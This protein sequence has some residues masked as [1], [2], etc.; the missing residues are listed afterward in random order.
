MAKFRPLP[1]SRLTNAQHFAF[2]D[3]FIKYANQTGFSAAKVLAA[4][5][6]LVTV[7]GSENDLYM[8]VKASEI[9][10]QKEAADRRRDSY[11]TRLHR[12]VQAWAGSGMAVLDAA[13][14]ELLKVFKLY[15]INTTAQLDEE[16]GLLLNL[17]TDLS[18]AENLARIEAINGTYLFEQL[19]AAN[20]EVVSLRLEQGVEESDKVKGALAAARKDT[21]ASYDAF[22][23]IIEGA[24]VFADDP[25]QYEQ[26][27]KVW[28]GTLKIYQDMLDRK[29]GS[30]SN[31]TSSETGNS[32]DSGNSGES[33]ETGNSGETG[34]SGD[35]GNSGESGNSGNS[36]ESGDNGGQQGGDNGGDDNGGGGGQ[37]PPVIDQD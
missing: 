15:K 3:A 11:Y 35:S 27:I 13:A 20:N 22:C 34:D 12:L 14:T 2:V 32:G 5:Q 6:T 9:I 19:V 31:G 28:N 30:G 36:G 17:I 7:F 21:D 18:T 25:T 24:S 1:K 33:G 8:V 26:F 10:A 4:L 16:T 23:A 29:S 37:N